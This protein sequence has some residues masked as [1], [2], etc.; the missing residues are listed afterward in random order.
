MQ[1]KQL[2]QIFNTAPQCLLP[3]NTS[4][5]EITEMP[6]T[7]QCRGNYVFKGWIA[8][9]SSKPSSHIS[10]GKPSL[11]GVGE[12]TPAEGP[13]DSAGGE[14]FLKRPRPELWY[15]P[16]LCPQTSHILFGP[17]FNILDSSGL[18]SLMTK[19]SSVP[20]TALDWIIVCWVRK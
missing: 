7:L 12:A 17:Q 1:V 6:L 2:P 11:T 10:Y 19:Y 15:S 5:M 16:S 4:N 20:P 18:D 9:H 14:S 8:T 13:S 3:L